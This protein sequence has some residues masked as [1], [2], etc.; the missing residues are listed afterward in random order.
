MRVLL[1]DSSVPLVGALRRGLE[2]EGY[3]VD[4]AHDGDESNRKVQTNTYDVI[5]LDTQLPHRDGL[6]LL[7]GWRR[8]GLQSHVLILTARG[9]TADKVKGLNIG[10]DDYLTKPFR[11]E[12]FQARLR[13]LVRRAYHAKD[14]V[15]RT[16]D[17]EID[18]GARC[19][20]R[21]GKEIR[22]TSREFDLLHFLALHQGQVVTRAMILQ[23]LYDPNDNVTS[24]VVDVFIGY[25][26]HKIDRGFQPPLILT[27]RGE[28]Y[29]LRQEGRRVQW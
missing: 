17:L 29:L 23:H 13:A 27:R 10:A 18:T 28:G 19:A 26:R 5:V 11:L 9:T 8:T 7:R 1:V 15:L 22:L 24:N 16:H 6:S 2:S 21:G 12:E 25:L 3:V 14:P 20:R 4:A